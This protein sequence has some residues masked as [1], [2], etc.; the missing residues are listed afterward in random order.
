MSS[1]SAS[2]QLRARA[3]RS[4]I[5]A[6][7]MLFPDVTWLARLHHLFPSWRAQRRNPEAASQETGLLRRFA[8][9]NDG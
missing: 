8:P 7:S 6:M 3:L 5:T 9:R 2:N 1:R 4:S